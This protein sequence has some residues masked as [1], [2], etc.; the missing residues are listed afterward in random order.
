MA[1]HPRGAGSESPSAHSDSEKSGSPETPY[2]DIEKDVNV[3]ALPAL[4]LTGALANPASQSNSRVGAG[5]DGEQQLADDSAS[6]SSVYIPQK[7]RWI[8]FSMIIFFA[9]GSSFAEGTLGPLKSTL[10]KQL[11]INSESPLSS[12]CVGL[13][14]LLHP[15]GTSL[16]KVPALLVRAGSGDDNVGCAAY[17]AYS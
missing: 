15:G 11:K 13:V 7:Y 8:A 10:V 4:S 17:A 9:T 1:P 6:E 14:P 16:A 12:L 5:E 2:A 3:S